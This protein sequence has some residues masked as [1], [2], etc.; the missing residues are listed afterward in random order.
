MLSIQAGER[1]YDYEVG[2]HS[3]QQQRSARPAAA[4]WLTG[5]HGGMGFE[6]GERYPISHVVYNWLAQDLKRSG[7]SAVLHG[8]GKK[9][10]WCPSICRRSRIPS[11]A[12]TPGLLDPVGDPAQ[13]WL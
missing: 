13:I 12:P 7:L 11:R 2:E 10:P 5:T 8:V 9:T 1:S 6:L 3:Y 4:R